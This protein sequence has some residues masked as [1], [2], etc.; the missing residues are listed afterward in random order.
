MGHEFL[1]ASRDPD[2][3]SHLERYRKG[4]WLGSVAQS[5]LCLELLDQVLK[6]ETACSCTWTMDT[7]VGNR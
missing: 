6:R 4:R 2:H 3:G 1:Q 7:E 5:I